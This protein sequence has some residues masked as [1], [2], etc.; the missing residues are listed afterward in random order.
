[1]GSDYLKRK[2]CHCTKHPSQLSASTPIDAGLEYEHTRA[3]IY[4]TSGTSYA[5]VVGQYGQCEGRLITQRGR[6]VKSA[7]KM[8][9]STSGGRQ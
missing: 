6:R 7:D 8:R 5:I 2:Y 4:C 3:S 9:K 1:M